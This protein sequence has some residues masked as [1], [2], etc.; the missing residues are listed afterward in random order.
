MGSIAITDV[1]ADDS[2]AFNDV[3][4]T[5]GDN[6][7]GSFVLTSGTW[8]F[9]L[10]QSAV[11]D[12]DVGDVVNDAI[13]YTATDG[14]TVQITVAIS[15]TDDAA[16]ISGTVAGA[17][18]EGNI[19]D[20]PVTA[21]GTIAISDVD[22]DDSPL[23]ADLGSTVGDNAYG[24]F[25]LTSGTWT[26]TLDQSAVQDLDAGD[27]VV[28]TITYTA[29]DV[30]VATMV[31]EGAVIGL[32]ERIDGVH[33][34]D[35]GNIVISTDKSATLGGLSFGPGDLVEYDVGSD[36][37]TL[38]FDGGALFSDPNTN[39]SAFHLLDNGHIV[40]G[41][42]TPATLGGLSF[43]ELDLVEYD[44]VTDTATLVFDSAVAGS[45]KTITAL[46]ILDNGHLVM[47][48]KS[49]WFINGSKFGV[50]QLVEYDPGTNTTTLY[51][52][53]GS[54]LVGPPNKL[55]AAHILDNGNILFSTLGSSTLGTVNF[56]GGDLVAYDPNAIHV[57]ST[58]QITVNITGTDDTSVITGTVALVRSSRVTLVMP[59]VTAT[60]SIAITD[61]DDDDNPVI[62][63]CR[64]YGR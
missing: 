56:D 20:A 58:Q 36:T 38:Y 44:P 24:S 18:N 9:T 45:N 6:A 29:T 19:G 10:D 31:L 42:D 33:M 50:T 3:G 25:V 57:P 47:S 15:G 11:Q 27:V 13:T 22:G 2:P 7:Y 23:F 39:V 21:T 61:V 34:L 32:T 53:I 35:S 8:T 5:V 14:S 28:D 51:S 40:L 52:D 54:Q 30:D 62:Q 46:H 16:V 59:P 26:Y 4:T 60:G 43:S 1:D 37:A 64:H 49:G 41:T 63:R 17:V 12:L 48:A 55:G